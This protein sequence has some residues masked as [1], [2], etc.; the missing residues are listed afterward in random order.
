MQ[1]LRNSTAFVTGGA[2]GIG[3]GMVR[4]FLDSGMRVVV[5][6]VRPDHLDAAAE[7]LDAG[8][9]CLFV[10]LDV[11]DR[12]GMGRAA[13]AAEEAF[14]PVHI[15]CNNAGIGMLGDIRL[16]GYDDWD[17]CLGVN[18]GGVVNGI[19]T[20]LPRM[21]AHGRPAH[22]VN[23]SSIGAICPG[24]NGVPYLT[25]KAAVIALSDTLRAD[26]AGSNVGVTTLIPGPTATRIHEVAALRPERFAR[27]GLKP[28]E[29]RLAAGPIFTGGIPPETVG[30]MVRDAI[31][32]ERPYVVTHGAF[33]PFVEAHFAQI[34]DAIP[35]ATEQEAA[36]LAAMMAGSL[37]D[38]AGT[39]S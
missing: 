35:P 6:D 5:A 1:D 29:D 9:K 20:F 10:E 24:P 3:L 26:L 8:D 25:A 38:L 23:T 36:A 21:L 19:Q 28:I 31:V 16:V 15:L 4:A 33:R 2:S 17:W 12:A 30:T 7:A 22:I 11:T 37:A 27:T 18:L 13:D 14:G 32:A 34:L 39:A